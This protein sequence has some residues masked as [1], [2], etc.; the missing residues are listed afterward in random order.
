MQVETWREKVLLMKLEHSLWFLETCLV[1]E[2][3]CLWNSLMLHLPVVLKLFPSFTGT[4]LLELKV[5]SQRKSPEFFDVARLCDLGALPLLVVF[6]N[7]ML[8]FYVSSWRNSSQI[9]WCC[10]YLLPWDP[11]CTYRNKIPGIGGLF[12][13]K[14]VQNSLMLHI[15][16]ILR[17]FLLLF[18]FGIKLLQFYVSPQRTSL[19]FF[20]LLSLET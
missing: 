20:H 18:L 3:G 2:I 16:V 19:K 9:H 7:K 4:K 8:Q 17:L 11:S 5:S 10:I 15:S 1:T 13:K 6:Q 12:L 14:Q